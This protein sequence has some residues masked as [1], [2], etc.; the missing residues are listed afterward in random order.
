[1]SETFVYPPP[2][3]TRHRLPDTRRGINHKFA[4]YGIDDEAAP[5]DEGMQPTKKFNFYVTVNCYE[6]GS[7]G[8]IF[9]RA[10]KE[11]NAQSNLF[12]AWCT[13]VSIALQSG[14]SLATIID[15]FK[16]WSFEPAGLTKN[17]KIPLCRSP[18]DYVCKWLEKRF[19]D[20]PDKSDES[21]HVPDGDLA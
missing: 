5:D 10:A 4:I 15:K 6:N 8:E 18:L 3:A 14:I 21:P 2:E 7:V 13:M 19:L 16:Y 11:G 20:V 1:M 17:S 9:V 12:D